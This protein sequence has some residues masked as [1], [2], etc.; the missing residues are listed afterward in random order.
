M[1]RAR[2]VGTLLVC[3]SL[4]LAAQAKPAAPPAAPAAPASAATPAGPI[5][6]AIVGDVAQWKGVVMAVNQ[7]SRH[8]IVKGQQGNLHQFVVP[9]SVPNLDSVKKGDTLNLAYVES[10]AIY[11]H[12]ANSPPGAATANAV[13]IAPKGMPAVSEIA[14]KEIQVNVTAINAAKREMTVVGPMGNSYTFE[15]DPSV[16]EFSKVKVGDQLVVRATEAVALSVAK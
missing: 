5:A 8:V 3:G 6:G 11:V 13:T 15:V 9:A 2:S 10:I 14:V 4:S 7:K 16:K 1:N 12:E